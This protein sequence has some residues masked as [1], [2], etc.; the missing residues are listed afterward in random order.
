MNTADAVKAIY[1]RWMAQWPGLSGS[2]PYVFDN[3][4][5]D[6]AATYA[7]VRVELLDEQQH[8]LGNAGAR[9]FIHTGLIE[10][11]LHAPG[12]TGRKAM[13]ALVGHVRTIFDSVRFGAVGTEEGV[14]TYGTSDEGST[15]DGAGSTRVRSNANAIV[16]V[17][18]T[19]FEFYEV[20]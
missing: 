19:E 8:T 14:I 15:T 16:R 12:N 4:V 10:V 5:A 2:T 6:S 3:D 7:R 11:E 9:K 20:R 1:Q 18:S 17:A 13:D